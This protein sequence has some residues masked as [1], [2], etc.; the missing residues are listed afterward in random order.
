MEIY[1]WEISISNNQIFNKNDDDEENE[2]K[3]LNMTGNKT[4]SNF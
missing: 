1:C 3:K 2:E 4:N